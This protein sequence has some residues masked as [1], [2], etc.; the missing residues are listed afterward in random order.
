[1]N[2]FMVAGAATAYARALAWQMGHEDYRA[3][4]AAIGADE[5]NAR[6]VFADVLAHDQAPAPTTTFTAARRRLCVP[7][8]SGSTPLT[9]RADEIRN[10]I[11]RL[12]SGT[13]IVRS[14]LDMP[15]ARLLEGVLSSAHEAGHEGCDISCN[16][17]T[18]DVSAGLAVARQILGA[19]RER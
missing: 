3:F 11:G 12:R 15:L 8:P 2:A 9:S 13:L 7:N 5:D 16:P 6:A 17:T 14:D 18:C 10:A 19:R 4:A 1:M